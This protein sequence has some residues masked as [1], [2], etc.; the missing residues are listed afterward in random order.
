[1]LATALLEMSFAT[2]SLTL[3]NSF[4]YRIDRRPVADKASNILTPCS[5]ELPLVL[6]VDELRSLMNCWIAAILISLLNS[7][8]KNH[9][10]YVFLIS[11]AI[12]QSL[13]HLSLVS[14]SVGNISLPGL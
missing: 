6:W 14:E 7:C 4:A 11:I 12:F 13:K 1:M 5:S 10:K 3:F 2:I 8:T 9:K